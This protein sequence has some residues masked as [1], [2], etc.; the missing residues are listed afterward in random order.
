ME[1]FPSRGW[2]KYHRHFPRLTYWTADERDRR[3][4][5]IEAVKYYSKSLQYT[6]T[7]ANKGEPTIPADYEQA[8]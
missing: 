1:N 2:M 7:K 6:L 5:Y 8:E 4:K 3:N